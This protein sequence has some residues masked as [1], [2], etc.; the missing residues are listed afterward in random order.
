MARPPGLRDLVR[1]LWAADYCPVY[2]HWDPWGAEGSGQRLRRWASRHQHRSGTSWRRRVFFLLATATWPIRVPFL[3][4]QNARR[5]AP[6]IADRCGIPVWRQ[7]LEQ[8][9]LAFR[10]SLP[11]V[12]YYHYELYHPAQRPHASEYLHQYEANCLLPYLN[13]YYRH[14]AIE[15]KREFARFCAGHGVPTVGLLG[16][17]ENGEFK[18]G[19]PSAEWKVTDIF[20]KPAYGARGGGVMLWRRLEQGDYQDQ[21]GMVLSWAELVEHLRASR[22]RHALVAQPRLRNHPE[23]ATLSTGAQCTARIVTGRT[24]AGEIAVVAGTFKMPWKNQTTDTHGLGAPID[25]ETGRLG[26]AWSYRPNCPG[27]DVH[28]DTAAEIIG[29][30]LPDWPKTQALAKEAHRLLPGYAFLG[31]DVAL[32]PAGPLLLEGNAGWDVL[33]VQKPQRVPLAQTRFLDIAALWMPNQL[34]TSRPRTISTEHF[35]CDATA[36]ETEPSQSRVNPR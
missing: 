35:A 20:V 14:P 31:W 36:C 17:F 29:R 25:L 5:W 10:H 16:I 33:T 9:W 7:C 27:Y 26:R 4:S 28:P 2:F 32:T 34:S 30:M 11:P 21:E 6:E 19:A 18:S 22:D 1:T 23:V 13:R 24:P 15:D 3:V 12:A 8:I